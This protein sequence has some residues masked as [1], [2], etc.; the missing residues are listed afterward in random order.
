MIVYVLFVCGGSWPRKL[1][2]ENISI[3]GDN[4]KKKQ[5][6]LLTFTI[7]QPS[8]NLDLFFTPTSTCCL[9]QPS[10]C[11]EQS[12]EPCHVQRLWGGGALQQKPEM[13]MWCCSTSSIDLVIFWA[14]KT[15]NVW[16]EYFYTHIYI[17]LNLYLYIP[18]RKL[19]GPLQK[20]PFV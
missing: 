3:K 2:M 17:Y 4:N 12:F 1:I 10:S 14:W 15:W 11:A 8:P 9:V 16:I 20:R 6:E 5:R 18:L 13:R 19:A 7:T